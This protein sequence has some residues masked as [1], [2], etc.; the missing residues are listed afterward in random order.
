MDLSF[1]WITHPDID[2]Q[3]QELQLATSQPLGLSILALVQALSSLGLAFRTNWKLTFVVLSTLPVI[4]VGVSLIS[5][6]GQRYVNRQ[7]SSLDQ[8][9][10]HANHFISNIV[11]VKCFNT[12][13]HER[14]KYVAAILQAARNSHKSCIFKGLQSGF[15]RFATTVIFVQG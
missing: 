9:I 10:K 6:R 2:R 4:L 13:A 1:W 11:M 15:V 5:R 12:Q 7:N 3:I 14:H 8:A